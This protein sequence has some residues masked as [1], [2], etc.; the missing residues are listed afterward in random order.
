[1][2]E[3]DV[4]DAVLD[5]TANE[6]EDDNDELATGG[7]DKDDDTESKLLEATPVESNED[8]LGTV[9]LPT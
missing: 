3:L 7:F 8:E 4:E 6:R 2:A 1:V 5:M 9:E